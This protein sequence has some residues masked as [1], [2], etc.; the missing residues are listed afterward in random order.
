MENEKFFSVEEFSNLMKMSPQ[1]IRRA[2]NSGRI[3][4]FR[5]NKGDKACF[6]IPEREINRI[7]VMGFK[8]TIKIYKS[9]IEDEKD[10]EST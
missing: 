3:L 5:I 9:H 7:I 1:T 10:T 2:I 8:E 4:A 6:R